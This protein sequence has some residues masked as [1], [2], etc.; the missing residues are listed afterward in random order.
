MT[1]T[2]TVTLHDAPTTPLNLQF[3]VIYAP[4][5]PSPV[6]AGYAAREVEPDVWTVTGY[7]PDG[8]PVELCRGALVQA[9]H[10][11]TTA[12]GM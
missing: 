7:Q 6:F 5:T 8:A 11:L 2:I 12:L 1:P 9:Y 3:G 4:R 10:R